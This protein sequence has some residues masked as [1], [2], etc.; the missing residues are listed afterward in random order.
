MLRSFSSEL[1]LGAIGEK[2]KGLAQADG[3][4][5]LRSDLRETA[6]MLGEIILKHKIHECLRD[7]L[8]VDLV[9]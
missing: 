1:E 3:A 8:A 9:M 2:L 6:S 7:V 5:G 4:F